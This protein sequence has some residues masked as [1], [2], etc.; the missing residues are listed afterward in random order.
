MWQ[1]ANRSVWIAKDANCG[2]KRELWQ[3]ANRS[4]WIAKDANCGEKREMNARSSER[5]DAKEDRK[6]WLT[7]S[8]YHSLCQCDA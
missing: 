2:E 4:V 8:M 3:A 7:L 6:T 1:A 5:E